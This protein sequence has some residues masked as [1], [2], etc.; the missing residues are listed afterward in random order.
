MPAVVPDVYDQVLSTN[1]LK[2]LGEFN[3]IAYQ[4][5]MTDWQRGRTMMQ[6][7]A[8]QLQK[9]QADLQL[10]AITRLANNAENLQLRAIKPIIEPDQ[11]EANALVTMRTGVDPL[12]QGFHGASMSMQLANAQ[13]TVN[14]LM[15]RIAALEAA[16]AAGK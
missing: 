4:S 16:M 3:T 9:Q 14:G 15:G 6:D 7:N 1:N 5:S 10:Q 2:N 11:E 13:A 12:S 8:L